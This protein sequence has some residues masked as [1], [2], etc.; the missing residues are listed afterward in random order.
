MTVL[1]TLIRLVFLA[2]KVEAHKVKRVIR[3]RKAIPAKLVL[4]VLKVS[5]VLRV[6]RVTRAI[7]AQLVNRVRKASLA[8]PVRTD[9]LLLQRSNRQAPVH[10]SQSPTKTA[11]QRQR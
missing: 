8:N 2:E 11:Q 7:L 1:P 10:E 4:R 9:I 6:R 3:A 5:L